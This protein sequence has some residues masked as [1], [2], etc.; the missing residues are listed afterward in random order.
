MDIK[1]CIVLIIA[2]T[3][4][5]AINSYT[6]YAKSIPETKTYKVR[7]DYIITST[8]LK[9]IILKANEAKEVVAPPEPAG[10]KLELLE[11]TC[12]PHF[13]DNVVPII[14]NKTVK[15]YDKVVSVVSYNGVIK[16]VNNGLKNATLDL[17]IKVIYVKREWLP[18]TNYEV[19]IK[20]SKPEPPFTLS[21]LIVKVTVENYLPFKVVDII[22]PQGRSLVN[23]AIQENYAPDEVS[24]DLKHVKLKFGGNLKEGVY[25]IKFTCD[26][27]AILPNCFIVAEEGFYNETLAK[28][29]TKDFA[30]QPHKGWKLLGYVVLIYS[31]LLENN[32]AFTNPQLKIEAPLVDYVYYGKNL[33]EIKGISY[34]VPPVSLTFWIKGYIVFGKWFKITNTYPINLNVL[35][36][37]ILIKEVGIWQK[38]MIQVTITKDIVDFAKYAYLII[39]IPPY[40]EV[41]DII[42]PSGVTLGKYV[43]T[44]CLW[45][46]AVRAIS[47]L[48]NEAYVQVK[49][50]DISEYGTYIINIKWLP[51][52]F[53]VVDAQGKP[54]MNAEIQLKGPLN[55]TATTNENGEANHNVY[56]PGIYTVYVNYKGYN[57]Y[58]STFITI[59][60]TNRELL[61]CKVYDLKVV[62]KN[63]LGSPVKNAKVILRTVNGSVM[64]V[65]TTNKDGIVI[66]K[67]LPST[68]YQIIASYKR[69]EKKAETMLNNTKTVEVVLDYVLEIP[70]IGLPLSTFEV[71][72]IVAALSCSI[73]AVKLLGSRRKEEEEIEEV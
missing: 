35:Y 68:A 12:K 19:K 34:L 45:G 65:E 16:I 5:L 67:Q 72:G 49:Y 7:V 8:S 69:I 3:L 6:P 54:L 39:Q 17:Y 21:N 62:V 59:M 38:E 51:F 40:G 64:E 60:P 61:K 29:Q 27:N 24:F 20:V 55:I 33:I 66:F 46:G 57:V 47:V 13:P 26:N 28:G 48:R 71:I 2:L 58:N 10:Y 44:K 23:P 73:I 15:E 41:T 32:Y 14:Y 43:E 1:K 50:N 18:I 42:T 56:K 9:E 25:T 30:I 53:H 4:V 52:K 37:P 22:D 63:T 70:V 36:A 31:T 11:V